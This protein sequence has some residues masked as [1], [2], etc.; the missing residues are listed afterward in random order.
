MSARRAAITTA[1]RSSPCRPRRS[2]DAPAGRLALVS[3]PVTIALDAMGGDQAPKMVLKGADKAL[4][5]F[6]GTH[7]LLFGDQAKI[8]PLLA[9]MPRLRAAS[10]VLHTDEAISPE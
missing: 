5:R 4:K 9:R 8:E 2:D 7:F 6:P 1:A 3:R 10:T